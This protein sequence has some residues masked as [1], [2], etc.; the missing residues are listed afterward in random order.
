M[1]SGLTFRSLIHFEFIFIY[2][3]RQCSNFILLQGAVQFSEHYLLKKLSFLWWISCLLHCRLIEHKYVG[4]FLSS[5]FDSIDLYLFLCQYH[6]I[7]MTAALYYSLK[8]KSIIPLALSFFFP[9]DWMTSQGL[10]WFHITF[11][12]ISSSSV[13][14]VMSILIRIALDL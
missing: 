2:G 10:L 12:I 14:N 5:L 11:R 3:V 7:L 4:L 13:K 1:V 9:Q 6:S 8:S